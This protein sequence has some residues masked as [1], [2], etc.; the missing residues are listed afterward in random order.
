MPSQRKF[1]VSQNLEFKLD[2]QEKTRLN[3]LTKYEKQ[4]RLDGFQLIAGV[5]EAG[6]GPLAGPVHAAACVLPPDFFVAGINDSKQLSADQREAIFNTLVSTN[7]IQYGIGVVS[8]EEIDRINIY[9]ASIKA[10]KQAIS[11]LPTLP[12]LILVDGMEIFYPNTSCRKIIQGDC[13]SQSIAAASILAKVSRDK[14]MREFHEQWPQYGFNQ[15]KGYSTEQ[16]LAAIALHGPCPI[17]RMSYEPLK[18]YSTQNQSKSI[19]LVLELN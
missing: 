7:E 11:L 13:L 16:H 8:H 9:Q 14:V 1:L 3:R 5:D 2:R 18:K 12:D 4:A 10:M 19:Q 17:H 15:H 6:R